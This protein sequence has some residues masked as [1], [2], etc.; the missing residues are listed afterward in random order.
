MRR[1]NPHGTDTHNVP[2][3]SL[4]CWRRSICSRFGQWLLLFTLALPLSGNAGEQPSLVLSGVDG[5]LADQIKT[6]IDL[7]SYSCEL[8][9]WRLKHLQNSMRK[10]A[11]GA[12]RAL[13]YYRSTIGVDIDTTKPC[14]ALQMDIAPG[15]PVIVQQVR[16]KVSGGLEQTAGY[17]KFSAQPLI[18][19]GQTLNHAAYEQTKSIVKRLA[20][21]Y[22]YFSGRFTTHRLEVDPGKGTARLDL[23]F[24]SGP[25]SKLGAIDVTQVVFSDN[26]MQQFIVLKQGEP[27]D[28]TRLTHQ[29]Q[30]L[31]DS[32]YF[33]SVKVT[34]QRDHEKEGIVPLRI[35]LE[36]RKR[37]AHRIGIG[38]STDVGPRVS[39]KFEHRWLNAQGHSYDLSTGWS[40]VRLDAGFNYHIPLGDAGAHRLDFQIG[41]Q[42]EDSDTNSETTVKAGA[43]LTRI[44]SN[45]WR[46]IL[47]LEALHED[48]TT[49]D[50]SDN[51][52][53]L[54]PGVGWSKIVRDNP[55]FVNRGWRFNFRLKA[56]HESL[57]SDVSMVQ[58]TVSA[59]VI[60]SFG[61]GRILARIGGGATDVNNFSKL[62]ASIRFF[63]GGDGTVRGFGYEDLGPKNDAGDVIGG[64]HVLT[65]SLEYEIPVMK[66]WGVALF[67]DAGNAFNQFNDY[68]PRVGAGAGVRW[69][70]P[71]GPVRVDIAKDVDGE[72]DL[73]L[74]ISMGL[75]L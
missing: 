64:K 41:F 38:A 5:D 65:G 30:V 39:Y 22:G 9:E 4:L 26:F 17:L 33:S 47:S 67:V 61:P 45:G 75:D 25:R 74:H 23:V 63:T 12:L 31:N 1:P 8:P 55:L 37:F 27:Y 2:I 70:S 19:T 57:F 28:S 69:H 7:S 46:R 15:D 59:K 32:G 43:H 60:R 11:A 50:S 48:F 10:K 6:A 72:E 24:E 21:R 68:E 18:A 35:E 34:P 16:L 53:L 44:L 42:D 71:I 58:A 73:R 14:W 3:H 66:D 54:M 56:A 13:G 40:P 62:P 20:S 52:F 51:V 49:A 29:Q 36:E